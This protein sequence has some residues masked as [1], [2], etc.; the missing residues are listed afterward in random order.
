MASRNLAVKNEWAPSMLI[1]PKNRCPEE[2]RRGTKIQLVK[3][4][5]VF[6]RKLG[7]Q[8]KRFV[9]LGDKPEKRLVFVFLFVIR[10]QMSREGL[11]VNWYR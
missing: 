10:P 2:A 4:P 8:D 9:T 7:C 5:G 3:D 11:P 1:C 6:D